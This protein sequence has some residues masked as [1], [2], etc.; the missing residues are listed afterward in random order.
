MRKLVFVVLLIC[1]KMLDEAINAHGNYLYCL[2]KTGDCTIRA[3]SKAQA[4]VQMPLTPDAVSG[5]FGLAERDYG[6][7]PYRSCA[8]RNLSCL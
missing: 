1:E 3:A 6:W 5:C 8:L 4:L 2:E 7:N